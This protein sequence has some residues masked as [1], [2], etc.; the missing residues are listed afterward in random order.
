VTARDEETGR[1]LSF[2][3]GLALLVAGLLN[4]IGPYLRRTGL[5]ETELY[6][7]FW[8]R[9]TA[10]SGFTRA[11]FGLGRRCV[12]H[13]PT[14][15]GP[16]IASGGTS[17]RY[18]FAVRRWE[19]PGK[20][21]KD[22]LLVALAA[23]SLLAWARGRSRLVPL[24]SSW[25]VLLLAALVACQAAAALARGAPLAA[26]AGLRGFAFLGVA[27]AAG[28]VTGDLLRRLVPWLLGLLAV[29][30][31]LAPVELLRGIPVQ[32]HMLLFGE[33]F[34]RRAMGTFVMPS[35]LGVTA[36]CVVAVAV[37]FGATAKQRALAWILGVLVV[38]ASGSATGLVL[39]GAVGAWQAL[40]GPR[41][42]SLVL[43]LA[44]GSL[45]LVH[46]RFDVLDSLSARLHGLRGLFDAP[47]LSLLFGRGIGLGTN[48]GS[49]LLGSVEGGESA[50]SALVLQT[51][52][53][54]L[55]LFAAAL[56]LAWARLAPA[57]PLLLALAAA[58]LTLSV[59]EAFPVNLLLGIVLA[60]DP[61][62]QGKASFV[63]AP[64]G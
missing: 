55:A 33:R 41:V 3:L 64:P 59:P 29:Q 43:T 20:A 19:L 10:P 57:R 13:R 24:S 7:S 17:A 26:V 40:S 53:A 49:R 44:A 31:L 28:W 39:L 45:L 18:V 35:T 37:G 25:P 54:G 16:A 60:C 52:L 62:I 63:D 56:G 21:M 32:G 34:A 51:G 58:C 42:V 27:L 8:A 11:P 30:L 12:L 61:A 48:A 47:P 9:H 22:L 38:L 6:E 23:G 1:R 2:W 4:G 36:A 15:D 5:I 14:D 46:G 50:V